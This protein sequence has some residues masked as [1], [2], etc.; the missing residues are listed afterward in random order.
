MADLAPALGQPGTSGA[1][2][3]QADEEYAQ[4]NRKRVGGGTQHQGED[5]GPDDF[6]TQR[7]EAT[8]GDGE[9][10]GPGG[11]GWRQ[12]CDWL[13]GNFIRCGSERRLRH[14]F[15]RQRTQRHQ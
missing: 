2:E 1:A 8:D 14:F 9:I 12:F 11:S 6:G 10:D 3:A 4:N 15:Q 13:W 7:A 5:A